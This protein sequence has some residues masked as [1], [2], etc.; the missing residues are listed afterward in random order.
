MHNFLKRYTAVLLSALLLATTT[1]PLHA[2][3]GQEDLYCTVNSSRQCVFPN[4]NY[5]SPCATNIES[6][7][8]LFGFVAAQV[9]GTFHE[10]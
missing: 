6:G 3:E 2:E 5:W 4:Q 9:C 1:A 7:T 10:A 8:Q